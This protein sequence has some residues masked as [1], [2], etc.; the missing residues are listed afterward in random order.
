MPAWVSLIV[1]IGAVVYFVL[2]QRGPVRRRRIREPEPVK[3]PTMAIP[4]GRV[5]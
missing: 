3:H 5:R 2:H 4:K 1:F